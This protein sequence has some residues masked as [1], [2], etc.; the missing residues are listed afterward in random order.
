MNF[1]RKLSVSI[2]AWRAWKWIALHVNLSMLS[3]QLSSFDPSP[4]QFSMTAASQNRKWILSSLSCCFASIEGLYQRRGIVLG[5]FEHGTVSNWA[6]SDDI[7]RIQYARWRTGTC[8]SATTVSA[9]TNRS[10]VRRRHFESSCLHANRALHELED[11]DEVGNQVVKQLR[12]LLL[13]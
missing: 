7:S 2:W 10:L 6:F 8:E 4:H 13:L 5:P 12:L 3:C 11:A 9:T 1:S